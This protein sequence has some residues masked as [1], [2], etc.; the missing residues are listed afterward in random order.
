MAKSWG[1]LHV[2][3]LAV[4]PKRQAAPGRPAVRSCLAPWLLQGGNEAIG[5]QGK[6]GWPREPP[7]WAL[8]TIGPLL[9]PPL[10]SI[11]G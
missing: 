6:S 11:P 10:E 2:P 8:V 4:N 5:L 7:R 1:R 3:L 9:A